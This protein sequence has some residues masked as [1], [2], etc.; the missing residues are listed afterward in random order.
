MQG[1]VQDASG[2]TNIAVNTLSFVRVPSPLMEGTSY[3][4]I[5]SAGL[6]SLT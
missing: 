6:L 4:V 3:R 5:K 1:S 2:N